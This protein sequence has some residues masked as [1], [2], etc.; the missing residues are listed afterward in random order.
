MFR[1]CTIVFCQC[2]EIFSGC[3]TQGETFVKNMD[4]M[5]DKNPETNRFV[6]L[7]KQMPYQF[8]CSKTS[9]YKPQFDNSSVLFVFP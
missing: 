2:I 1:D 8:F 5:F 4:I 7:E 6:T 9:A 3:D